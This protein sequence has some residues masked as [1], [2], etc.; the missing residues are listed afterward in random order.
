MPGVHTNLAT[1]LCALSSDRGHLPFGGIEGLAPIQ[2]PDADDDQGGSSD[3]AGVL[4]CAAK[5]HTITA[6]Q[7]MHVALVLRS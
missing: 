3:P 1:V 5:V 6:Q 2:V 4:E 7:D